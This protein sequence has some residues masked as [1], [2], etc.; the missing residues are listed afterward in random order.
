MCAQICHKG[1]DVGYSR[2][3]SFFCDCGADSGTDCDRA[4]CK[5]LS[6]LSDE[7]LSSIHTTGLGIT[8]NNENLEDDDCRDVSIKDFSF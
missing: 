5:C 8:T 7:T 4:Q 1:H 6:L 3:S 2:K